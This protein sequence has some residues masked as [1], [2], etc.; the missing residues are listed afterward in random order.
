MNAVAALT[1]RQMLGGRRFW[2]V[3]L[4]LAL[5]VVLAILFRIATNFAPPGEAEVY[6]RALLVY[7]LYPQG[8]CLLL[9][10]LYGTSLLASE[11]EGKTL[12]YL[13]THAQSRGSVLVWKFAGT[14]AALGVLGIASM[15]VSW[16]ILG[17]PLGARLWAA[18]AAS[19]AGASAV[20]TAIFALLGLLLPRRAIPVGLLYILVVELTLSLVPAVVNEA[21]ASYYLRSLSFRILDPDLGG[22]RLEDDVVPFLLRM[23]GGAGLAASAAAIAGI[24]AAAVGAAAVVF[25]HGEYPLTE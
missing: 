20:Y 23:F 25:R 2:F 22:L 1:L 18:L 12:V 7:A 21:T 17:A 4:L 6:L 16:L 5:P 15:T 14:A 13:V 24:T 11:I 19:V 10:L 9:C 3:L 8:V